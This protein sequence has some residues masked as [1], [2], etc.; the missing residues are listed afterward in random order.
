M[1]CVFLQ[2]HE[3]ISHFNLFEKTLKKV[4]FPEENVL[5]ALPT[6]KFGPSLLTKQVLSILFSSCHVSALYH[7][8]SDQ[9][10]FILEMSD[11]VVVS[12]FI[13]VHGH[14]LLLPD[15]GCRSPPRQFLGL[16]HYRQHYLS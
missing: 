4:E 3:G 15:K 11:F 10:D 16:N 1:V 2:V 5:Q 6:L 13:E 8:L 7:C 12:I 14:K 9:G